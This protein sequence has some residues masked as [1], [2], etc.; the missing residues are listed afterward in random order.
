M[1][2]NIVADKSYV[3]AL[4]IIN[5]FRF[6][7]SEHRE[8]VL[9]KQLLR[10]G[11]AVGALIREAEHAQSNADF[12]HKMSISLKEANETLYW[13]RL[14]RDSGYLPANE[15]D[16]LFPAAEELV[17]LLVSI[18]KTMKRRLKANC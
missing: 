18:V 3:F 4:S 1:A 14:L 11:T 13:L 17:R 2:Q 15:Y 5:V 7:V 6:M 8:Y 12:V 16:R 9:S 10:S